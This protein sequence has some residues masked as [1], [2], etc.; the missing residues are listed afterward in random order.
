MCN[1]ASHSGDW[2]ESH[3]SFP[4]RNIFWKFPYC[5]HVKCGLCLQ[6]LFSRATQQSLLGAVISPAQLDSTSCLITLSF[7]PKCQKLL[8]LMRLVLLSSARMKGTPLHGKAWLNAAANASVHL[9]IPPTNPRCS[10]KGMLPG[11]EEQLCLHFLP[12]PLLPEPAKPFEGEST[13]VFSFSLLWND[14]PALPKMNWLLVGNNRDHTIA[15]QEKSTHIHFVFQSMWQN[16]GLQMHMWQQIIYL[17]KSE[18]T[19]LIVKCFSISNS[20]GQ[21]FFTES[22]WC[23]LSCPHIPLD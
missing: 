17:R 18:L 23:H 9:L 5:H 16:W 10:V 11:Q 19:F 3:V 2:V 7:W 14:I 22:H 13:R 21:F 8:I 12:P 15:I 20:T 6:I 1:N 4:N